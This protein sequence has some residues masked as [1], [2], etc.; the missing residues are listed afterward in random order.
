MRNKTSK[1]HSPLREK[2]F[3]LAIRI[4]KLYQHLKNEKKEFTLS[5]QILRSGTNPGAMV[6]EAGNAESS[7]DFVHKLAIAQKELGETQYWL[8]LLKATN[9]L[10][11]EEH[12]SI[13]S[14]S[15][16]VMKMVR[17]S[18]HTKK[19]NLKIKT[20]TIIILIATTFFLLG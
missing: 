5:K 15:E 9:Y 20:T 7:M 14:D 17:S 6:R 12:K 2:L 13:Y 16:E 3:R 1:P 4:V 10:S 19:K 18:I 11:E 8:D